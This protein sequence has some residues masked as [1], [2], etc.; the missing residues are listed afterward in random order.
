MSHSC[1]CM[2][3]TQTHKEKGSV[4]RCVGTMATW[5]GDV[6]RTRMKGWEKREGWKRRR[7]KCTVLKASHG[8]K[9][10]DW[11]PKKPLIQ[12]SSDQSRESKYFIVARPVLT[13][14]KLVLHIT[15]GWVTQRLNSKVRQWSIS[16]RM[17]EINYFYH[18]GRKGHLK[19]SCQT[20]KKQSESK[21]INCLQWWRWCFVLK[22]R[23][24]TQ[25]GKK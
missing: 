6:R 8:G 18:Y 10:H 9:K 1:I 14:S 7:L 15:H 19:F 5:E 11:F 13:K 23:T 17:T 20:L 3:Y 21:S 25:L 12:L 24:E 4:R 16:A 2:H 22:N